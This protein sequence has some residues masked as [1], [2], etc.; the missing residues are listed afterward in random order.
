VTDPTTPLADLLAEVRARRAE[1]RRVRDELAERRAAGLARR[2]AAKLAHWRRCGLPP[3]L[4]DLAA[5]VAARQAVQ[6]EVVTRCPTPD[7]S[8]S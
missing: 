8:S 3:E 1:Q 7:T 4:A 2:H 5:T 6:D